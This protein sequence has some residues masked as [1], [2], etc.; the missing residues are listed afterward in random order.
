M[1]AVAVFPHTRQLELI[2][3]DEPRLTHP[4][5]VKVRDVAVLRHKRSAHLLHAGG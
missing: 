1:K 3:I 4:S 2:E 5:D